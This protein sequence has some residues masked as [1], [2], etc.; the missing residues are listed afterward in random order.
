MIVY[1]TNCECNGAISCDV[2]DS[3]VFPH[4]GSDIKPCSDT[5]KNRCLTFGQCKNVFP[6][7]R[8]VY[9]SPNSFGIDLFEIFKN[10][11]LDIQERPNFN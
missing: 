6:P 11:S 2:S 1:D 10:V 5:E 4:G 8:Q 9:L 7:S 3:G